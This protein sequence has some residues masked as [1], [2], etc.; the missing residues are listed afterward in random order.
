[1]AIEK[2]TFVEL[3]TELTDALTAIALS[4]GLLYDQC[5]QDA[6]WRHD[7][8]LEQAKYVFEASL[9]ANAAFQIMF[10]GASEGTISMEEL[11]TTFNLVQQRRPYN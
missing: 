10:Q 4:S 2:R 7:A 3:R 11:M 6:I 1:M 8:K 9:V 5:R